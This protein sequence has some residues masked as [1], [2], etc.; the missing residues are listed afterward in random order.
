MTVIANLRLQVKTLTYFKKEIHL[1]QTKSKLR[2]HIYNF[3][4][5]N[6]PFDV[7]IVSLSSAFL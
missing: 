1:T 6:V 4:D 3:V 2:R 5:H 7:A